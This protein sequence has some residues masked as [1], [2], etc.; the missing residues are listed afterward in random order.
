MAGKG[1]VDARGVDGA[2]RLLL[3]VFVA[4]IWSALEWVFRM[5]LRVQPCFSKSCRTFR[6]ASLSF[7][8]SMR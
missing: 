5:A 2:A 4:S 1:A 3:Q 7:P 8:L 6:P